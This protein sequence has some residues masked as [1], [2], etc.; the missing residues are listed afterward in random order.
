MRF[1]QKSWCRGTSPSMGTH[2]RSRESG[3]PKDEFD[4]VIVIG[5]GKAS[6]EM[7]AGV[8]A[9][10]QN[11]IPLSGWVNVPEG[12]RINP[13]PEGARID[14]VPEGARMDAAGAQENRG[15]QLGNIHL[16]PA[17]PIGVNEP[18][19]EAVAGTLEILRRVSGATSR[20]LCV[21]LD[22]G[23]RKCV[24]AVARR[25][26]FTQRQ[27]CRDSPSQRCGSRHHS[28]QH[29]AKTLERDQGWRAVTSVS[30]YPFG[31][32]GPVG[33]LGRSFGFDRVGVRRSRIL[34][35]LLTRFAFCTAWIPN[36]N[37]L[38]AFIAFSSGRVRQLPT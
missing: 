32:V 4:R 22:F 31:N 21:A 36:A 25:R 35:V 12:A 19:E 29:G 38:R 3:F 33:R 7:A 10:L 17:R 37:C 15:T 11:T 27:T 30:A 5:A 34:Q 26:R 14:P 8:H 9:I 18:T 16:H 23:R 6:A 28:A 2:L 1:G 20:D 24:V 13:V